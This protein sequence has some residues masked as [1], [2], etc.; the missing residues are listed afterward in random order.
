MSSSSLTQSSCFTI[1]DSSFFTEY[2][3]VQ[4]SK[5]SSQTKLEAFY[6]NLI[7]MKP[8][9]FSSRFKCEGSEGSNQLR[10]FSSTY[11]A[12]LIIDPLSSNCSNATP[13]PR[14][15]TNVV[16]A[17]AKSLDNF[18]TRNGCSKSSKTA[19][20]LRRALSKFSARNSNTDQTGCLPGLGQEKMQCGMFLIILMR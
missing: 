4:I 18:Y 17:A 1:K 19:I 12:L 11:F 13:P 16:E 3:D 10:Y 9:N 6:S 8:S 2:G 5:A 20:N 7:N 14:L 15:C